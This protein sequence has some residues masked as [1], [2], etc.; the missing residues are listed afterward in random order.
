MTKAYSLPSGC[1]NTLLSLISPPSQERYV[2]K[3]KLYIGKR[4][5]SLP[6]SKIRNQLPIII[7]VKSS[8]TIEPPFAKSS[9]VICLMS[10][11]LQSCHLIMTLHDFTFK[12]VTNVLSQSSIRSLWIPNPNP[13]HYKSYFH[14]LIKLIS[15]MCYLLNWAHML[16]KSV[17]KIC[18]NITYTIFYISRK[19][20]LQCLHFDECCTPINYNW[21]VKYSN[22]CS[23]K[24]SNN[25]SCHSE[26]TECC[27]FSLLW[28]VD[29]EFCKNLPYLF[30]HSPSLAHQ[31]N[32]DSYCREQDRTRR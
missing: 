32:V 1:I 30:N 10:F 19:Y 29:S 21:S 22:N 18:W 2:L 3:T 11:F 12:M 6:A 16:L 15:L 5:F 25:C 28:N 13:N 20:D 27:F 9:K 24:Y 17:F 23:V 8:E 4:A 26:V 14:F 7:I 31:L